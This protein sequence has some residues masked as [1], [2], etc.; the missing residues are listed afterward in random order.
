MIKQLEIFH[1]L[2]KIKIKVKTDWNNIDTLISHQKRLVKAERVKLIH[3]LLTIL[4]PRLLENLIMICVDYFPGDR[5][6]GCDN[7]CSDDDS[8]NCRQGRW[9]RD[10]RKSARELLQKYPPERRL[11]CN[12]EIELLL[13]QYG[14]Y[15]SK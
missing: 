14:P 10:S 3:P 8:C 5:C 12:T 9:E 7:Y 2:E 6:Y 4:A 1:K 13:R 15:I 11:D